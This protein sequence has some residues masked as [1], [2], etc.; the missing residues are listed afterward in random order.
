MIGFK[1]TITPPGGSPTDYTSDVTNVNIKWPATTD[2]PTCAVTFSN[3]TGRYA[4]VP[5]FGTISI[6]L[7]G[8]GI[9]VL[10]GNPF[11][12]WYE[13]GD[14]TYTVPQGG[15]INTGHLIIVNGTAA[16][17]LLYLTE[18][19]LDVVGTDL[20]VGEWNDRSTL[21]VPY[22]STYNVTLGTSLI[23]I[24][25]IFT[26]LLHT[27]QPSQ[28]T[29]FRG[30]LGYDA[31]GAGINSTSGLDF[32]AGKSTFWSAS[33]LYIKSQWKVGLGST[34]AQKTGLDVIKDVAQNN[35]IDGGGNPQ[36]ID[37]YVLPTTTPYLIAFQRA[38]V[39]S[40]VGF[41]VGVDPIIS[42]LP[43]FDTTS[44]RN[45]IIYWSNAESV[46]PNSGD[47]WSN[48]D[49]SPNMQA[50]WTL[51]QVSGSTI[52]EGTD[53]TV[54]WYGAVGASSNVYTNTST[55]SQGTAITGFSL[56]ARGYAPSI[57]SAR[58]TMELT[59]A[60]A[61]LQ[62]LSA[63]S[64]TPII[65]DFLGNEIEGLGIVT[66]GLPPA[67]DFAQLTWAIPA[68]GTGTWSVVSGSWDFAVNIIASVGFQL[69][70]GVG[71]P[72][73]QFWLDYI[74]FV[75]A[76]DYSP[77]YS[78]NP[79]GP[80]VTTLTANYLAGVTSL[81]V[82]STTGLL[83]GQYYVVGFGTANQE[84]VMI[85][86]APVTGTSVPVSHTINPHSMGDTCIG[87]THDPASIAAFGYRIFNNVDFYLSQGASDT[88]DLIA[89]NILN[90]RKAKSSSGS[91]TVS[92]YCPQVARIAPG[93]IFTVAD[94]TDV[95]TGGTADSSISGWIADSIEY[96]ITN[97]TTGGFSVTYTIEPYYS[98]IGPTSPDRNQRDLY[99][100]SNRSV[101]GYARRLTRSTPYLGVPRG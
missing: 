80:E 97:T 37:F 81:G 69:T 101:V 87:A 6:T 39:G 62:S 51:T 68:S 32:I 10:G 23:D 90:T 98:A 4:S 38:T 43:V 22:I 72:A 100:L 77:V 73:Q 61:R 60:F 47:A 16:P 49:T 67:G 42:F 36:V 74:N 94:P 20:P 86:G 2:L 50:Q 96:N 41:T 70:L 27:V 91:I 79:L 3:Q 30:R 95:Y 56:A 46:Y 21:Y 7:P 53:N 15:G 34:G 45:F 58:G 48:Y 33:G 5:L 76:W 24:G 52:D 1:V 83:P 63:D 12:F 66:G 35:V 9:S 8:T 89:Y 92:G 85:T 55:G 18:G 59:C 44:V 31:T 82:V 19:N 40:T 28:T 88:A 84:V 75:D 25:D 26:G 64:I 65:A 29:G 78:Y 99:A 57:A 11:V 17:E 13:T 54:S 14:I 93:S 71:T